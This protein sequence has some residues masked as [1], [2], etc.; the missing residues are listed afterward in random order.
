M[1]WQD[2][3]FLVGGFVGAAIL[4]PTLLDSD[5]KVPRWSSVPTMILLL[6]YTISFYTLG[7][8]LSALG[9]LAGALVWTGIAAFRA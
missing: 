2:L 4:L 7:M 6:S 5:A 3:V 9:S 8:A 1:M